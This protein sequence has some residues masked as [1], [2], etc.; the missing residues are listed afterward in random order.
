MWDT[1]V[2]N[3][4][5]TVV[6]TPGFGVASGTDLHRA[7]LVSCGEREARTADSETSVAEGVGKYCT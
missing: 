1:G 4:S 7:D 6:Q 2:D 3:L 5:S